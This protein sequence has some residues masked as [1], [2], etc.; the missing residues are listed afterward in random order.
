[1]NKRQIKKLRKK[2]NLGAKVEIGRKFNRIVIK[3][4]IDIK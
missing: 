2:F 3:Y 4:K 1:M